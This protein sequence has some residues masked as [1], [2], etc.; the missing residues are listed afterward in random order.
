MQAV[1]KWEQNVKQG[2][3][4]LYQVSHYMARSIYKVARYTK[5]Y[6]RYKF[7]IPGKL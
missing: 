7:L 4:A 3:A 5:M 1:I 2:K 6:M